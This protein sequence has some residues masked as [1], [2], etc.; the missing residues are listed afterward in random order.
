MCAQTG[1]KLKAAP[2]SDF[3]VLPYYSTDRKM[4]GLDKKV[5]QAFFNQ[6]ELDKVKLLLIR[7]AQENKLKV[8]MRQYI[9]VIDQHGDKWVWVNCF[10]NPYE[11]WRTNVQVVLDG[12]DCYYSLIINLT[13][14]K[15]ENL[16]VNGEA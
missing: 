4:F 12:G 7:A 15:Y 9:C 3:A 5:K 6:T 1:K 10:C 8:Y 11:G 16:I 2:A 13:T 14:G